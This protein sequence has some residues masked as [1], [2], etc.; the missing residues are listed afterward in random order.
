M[1]WCLLRECGRSHGERH[2]L[3]HLLGVE[4]ERW[5][6]VHAVLNSP[7]VGSKL[8]VL[9]ALVSVPTR[10]TAEVTL[11]VIA[12]SRVEAVTAVVTARSVLSFV[13]KHLLLPVRVTVTVI[14]AVAVEVPPAAS[15]A[16]AAVI[17]IPSTSTSP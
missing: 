16:I 17:P 3:W 12:V 9:I 13:S 7:L 1:K 15:V 8:L 6:V 4:G 11:S 5:R 2:G 10:L 14:L